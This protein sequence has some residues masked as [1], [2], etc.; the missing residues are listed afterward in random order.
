MEDQTKLFWHKTQLGVFNKFV[1]IQTNNCDKAVGFSL[2]I[3]TK[4]KL[5]SHQQI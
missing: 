4:I 2:K 5:K 3:A 1:V